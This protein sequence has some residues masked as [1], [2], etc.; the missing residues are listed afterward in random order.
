MLGIQPWIKTSLSY[1]G[2]HL[3]AH[4]DGREENTYII[5]GGNMWFKA[6]EIRVKQ[7]I[8][9]TG[10]QIFFFFPYRMIWV[11]GRWHLDRKLRKWGTGACAIWRMVF[12]ASK[13]KQMRRIWNQ[14]ICFDV[15]RSTKEANVSPAE[16]SRRKIA[17]DK[18]SGQTMTS[19][20]PPW[21]AGPPP[22]ETDID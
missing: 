9:R 21:R 22:G 14:S 18:S 2:V 13:K 17:A 1:W 20:I 16:R 19:G 3:L 11:L 15:F 4:A 6:I 7:K 5:C 12:P 8:N 10:K